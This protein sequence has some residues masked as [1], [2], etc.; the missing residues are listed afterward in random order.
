MPAND[1]ENDPR[2][3]T[4]EQTGIGGEINLAEV[5]DFSGPAATSAAPKS[6]LA[7]GDEETEPGEPDAFKVSVSPERIDQLLQQLGALQAKVSELEGSDAAE[8]A[9]EARDAITE[10]LKSI[11][12]EELSTED[13]VKLT[14]RAA[15]KLMQAKAT[16][17][18]DTYERKL[19]QMEV[20]FA[21]TSHVDFNDLLEGPEGIKALSAE[22]PNW[23]VERCYQFAKR[24]SG[25]SGNP[26][27]PP[28]GNLDEG[29]EKPSGRQPSRPPKRAK[30]G[31]T[32]DQAI[33]QAFR[34]L[35][36]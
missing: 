14:V 33:D 24:L 28:R 20:N 29:G 30:G 17:L 16:E 9:T 15:E 13:T 3:G 25:T 10:D 36:L 11:N 27:K 7:E 4:L 18:Q 22:N 26:P 2:V 1:V 12:Y 35:G 34:D 31:L 23:S 6:V 5:P 8:R 32:A 19:A 21:K